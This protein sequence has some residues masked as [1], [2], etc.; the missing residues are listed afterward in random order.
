MSRKLDERHDA[1]NATDNPAGN[2]HFRDLMHARLTRRQALMGGASAATTAV[3]GSL[4]L[5]ACG[6]DNDPLPDEAQ[7]LL[8]FTAVPKSTADT[9]TVPPGYTA[10]VLL[11]WGQ[12]LTAG[13]SLPSR[14]SDLTVAQQ[15]TAAGDHHDG[16]AYFGLSADSATPPGTPDR[17]NS[18]RGLL[19][20]N[21]EAISEDFAHPRGPTF[22]NLNANGTLSA[23][24]ARTRSDECLKEQALHGVAVVELKK[25]LNGRFQ[26]VQDSPFN[27]RIDA[28]T[29]MD[30]TG[31]VANKPELVLTRFSAQAGKAT[32]VRGTLNNCA[33]GYT[34]WGTYLTCEENWAGYFGNDGTVPAEQSRYGISRHGFQNL[35][36][37][38][39]PDTADHRMSR[40]Q[41]NP[42][43]ADASEDF[44]NE[45]NTFGYVVEIDPYDPTAVPKKRSAMG[46]IAH[47]GAWPKFKAGRKIAFYM[48]DDSRNE[49][50][51]KFVTDAVYTGT[52]ARNNDIL[53]SGTLYV[54]VFNGDGT[55][56]WKPLTVAALNDA[57]NFPT[58]A[59]ICVKTRQ[60]ADAAGATKMDRPEWGA[61]HPQT[62]EVYLAL[63]NNSNRRPAGTA[64]TG[65]QVLTDAANPRAYEDTRSAVAPF[66]SGATNR[67][68]NNGHII[69]LRETDDD[70]EATA[71]TWDVY[72]FGAEASAGAAVN[73][74]RLS[75]E[76]DFSS[77][78]GLWFD[79]RGLLWIQT[80]D[81]AYTD[82]TNCMLLAAVPGRVGDGA[83]ITVSN[84]VNGVTGTQPT[85]VG[86]AAS[87][88]TLRRFLVGPKGCEITGIAMTPDGKTLFVNIQHPGE[89]G[90]WNSYDQTRSEFSQQSAFNVLPGDIRARSATLVITRNDGGVIGL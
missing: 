38:T 48:G 52:E 9:V 87:V 36:W 8:G 17:N 53:D 19:A 69:R 35:R 62:G 3:F 14:I 5:S 78:D 20:V 81:G 16:M 63:T 80:D 61:V 71:F 22:N 75:A 50:F 86:A 42:T 25:D 74:S 79:P 77:P 72:L 15:Q 4:G 60:A 49:Y 32:K 85:R 24:S 73:L 70:P 6:S 66:I 55:G 89:N 84:T 41:L 21:F 37:Y 51:Y 65:S 2:P 18:S 34:P 43:G 56:E 11:S 13:G 82:V 28:T 76:N 88:N 57:V 29:E 30:I 1:D 68:N 59:D 47:E 39:A 40:F 45:A 31:P 33:N 58:Q 7:S 12:P 67:G 83:E 90:G 46:R 23:A 64:V 10:R 44:R 54:A 27:R 26:V